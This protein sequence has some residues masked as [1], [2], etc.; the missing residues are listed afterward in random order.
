M[1]AKDCAS[2]LFSPTIT[3]MDLPRDV[4]SCIVAAVVVVPPPDVA[5]PPVP[6][7]DELPPAPP[8]EFPLLWPLEMVP[9]PAPAADVKVAG[10]EDEDAVEREED[11]DEDTF[12][13]P[14]G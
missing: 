14:N 12:N 6:L 9:P 8:P 2:R 4:I 10:V 13:S 3:M 1:N 5:T 11:I 7:L